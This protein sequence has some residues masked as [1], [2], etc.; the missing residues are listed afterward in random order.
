MILLYFIALSFMIFSIGIV[1]AATTRHFLLMIISVEIIISAAILLSVA[2]FS[3]I[4]P[5]DILSLLF[6]LWAVAASE[7]MGMI[8]IYR[9]M[10]K[11]EM[12]MDVRKLFKLQD[13]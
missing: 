10:C 11:S 8:V 9:Y 1:A 5:G 4:T 12:S 7:I 6:A 13:W 3:Y 2:T